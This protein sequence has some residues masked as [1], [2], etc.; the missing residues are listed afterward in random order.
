MTPHC[1]KNTACYEILHRV[2]D[3]DEPVAGYCEDG[4]E[5]SGSTKGGEFLD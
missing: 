2:S 4:N 1:K 3:L 5:F